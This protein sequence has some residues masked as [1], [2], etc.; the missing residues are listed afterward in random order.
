M[1]PYPPGSGPSPGLFRQGRGPGSLRHH[2]H[3]RSLRPAQGRI[4]RHPVHPRPTLA[5]TRARRCRPAHEHQ[6]D[7]G[8][9]HRAP[10]DAST[11]TDLTAQLAQALRHPYGT[12]PYGCRPCSAAAGPP[13]ASTTT[14]PQT[15][16]S[17]RRSPRCPR[18]LDRSKRGDAVA[19]GPG[20]TQRQHPRPLLGGW[21]GAGCAPVV[22]RR[23]SRSR[24]TDV[25]VASA[26]VRAGRSA[27]RAGEPPAGGE[28][29]RP[30]RTCPARPA[31]TD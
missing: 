23:A 4:Q 15:P 24:V 19:A 2:Q 27:R 1:G 30:D 13:W 28:Q 20:R 9:Q 26:P 16:R 14:P 31:R 5:G 22:R 10:H 11:G 17:R 6:P 25:A 21:C 7:P 29:P 18:P 8:T 3:R 12:P